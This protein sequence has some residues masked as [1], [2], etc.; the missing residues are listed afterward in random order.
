MEPS[1]PNWLS[2]ILDAAEW[3]V[4]IGL[5]LLLLIWIFVLPFVGAHCLLK[6]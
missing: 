2:A 6:H 3:A 4:P 1:L 5:V